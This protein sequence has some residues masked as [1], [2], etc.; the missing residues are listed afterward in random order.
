MNAEK[1]A[2]YKGLCKALRND[3]SKVHTQN[4]PDSQGNEDMPG[5]VQKSSRFKAH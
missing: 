5:G 1:E 4:T 2:V 3:I